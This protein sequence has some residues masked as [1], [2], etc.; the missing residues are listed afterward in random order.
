MEVRGRAKGYFLEM[1]LVVRVCFRVGNT[2]FCGELR[3]GLFGPMI[4]D[5]VST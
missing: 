3:F 1:K 5:Y 2:R 4:W